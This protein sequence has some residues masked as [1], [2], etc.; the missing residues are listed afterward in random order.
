MDVVLNINSYDGNRTAVFVT[1]LRIFWVPVN[2][3]FKLRVP[4][5]EGNFTY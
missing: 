4:G 2:M 3:I 1:L 5:T